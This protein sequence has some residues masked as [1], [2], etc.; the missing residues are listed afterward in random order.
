MS[1][2]C[3]KLHQRSFKNDNLGCATDIM[4]SSIA[5]LASNLTLRMK[6]IHL[7]SPLVAGSA[8]QLRM[9]CSGTGV[10]KGV[11][12]SSMPSSHV[13]IYCISFVCVFIILTAGVG[14]SP[15][16]LQAFSDQRFDFYQKY[17]KTHNDYE[18]VQQLKKTL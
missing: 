2:R 18:A 9:S 10:I 15:V 14:K 17:M 4:A 8:L 16:K 6:H 5:D 7:Q 12:F 3:K 11:G 1:C 13:F